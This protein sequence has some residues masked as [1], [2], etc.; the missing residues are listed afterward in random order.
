MKPSEALEQH[1]EDISRIVER[2][3]ARNPRVFGSAARGDDTEGSDLDLLVDPA[4]TG[5]VAEASVAA[6]SGM[7]DN[8]KARRDGETDITVSQGVCSSLPLVC[9]FRQGGP[10]TQPR[11]CRPLGAYMIPG[12]KASARAAESRVTP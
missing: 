12:M 9:A 1:R 3:D 5:T 8:I 10:I 6:T 11:G 4:P 7:G 2:N